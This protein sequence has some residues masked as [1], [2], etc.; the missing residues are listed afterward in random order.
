[1]SRYEKTKYARGAELPDGFYQNGT[2]TNIYKNRRKE[3]EQDDLPS[4]ESGQHPMIVRALSA[5][6]PGNCQPHV[7]YKISCY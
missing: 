7:H 5:L 4:F 1:M 3:R 6:S 2:R